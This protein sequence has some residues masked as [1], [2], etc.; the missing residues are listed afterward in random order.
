AVELQKAQDSR[1]LLFR[2]VQRLFERFDLLLTPTMT[3]PPTKIDADGSVESAMYA[4]HAAPLY[5]FN[6]T[7]HPAASVPAG[8]TK[9]GLPV[10]LQIV[11]PWFAEKRILKVAAELET[12]HRWNERW[13]PMVSPSRLPDC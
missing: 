12:I 1:T 8:F 5:P 11:G 4:E 9:S 2:S 6:L 7:G 3:A 13:P 10:G